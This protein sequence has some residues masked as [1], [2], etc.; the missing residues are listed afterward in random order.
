[1]T[2]FSPD[3]ELSFQPDVGPGPSREVRGI[4]HDLHDGEKIDC[5]IVIHRPV[6]EVFEYWRDFSNLPRFIKRL[7]RVE[8]LT[9][10]LTR[11]T[12]RTLLGFE[13][14]WDSEII[15]EVPGRM[16]S[17]QSLPGANLS[18][19][20][21]VWF[22]P[23]VDGSTELRLILI[24]RL[25]AHKVIQDVGMKVAG[26]VGEDPSRHLRG[27]LQSLKLQLGVGVFARLAMID[28]PARAG[29]AKKKRLFRVAFFLSQLRLRAHHR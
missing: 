27:D 4:R 20:G 28:V 26:L 23:T 16:I 12:Y 2:A 24:Y 18:I 14:E 7:E 19:A 29:K 3:P 10:L 8:E 9:P 1:M 17:W 11:W 25:A 21:S 6:S 13:L 22:R 15:A 5:T